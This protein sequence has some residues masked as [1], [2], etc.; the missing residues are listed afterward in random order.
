MTNQSD[1]LS[2]SLALLER[3]VGFD[4]VSTKTN[5]PLIEAVESYLG[6][7]GIAFTRVPNAAG[8][9][10]ALFAT[11]GPAGDGGVRALGPHGR[12][13]G[14]GPGLG[15]RSR[16]ACGARAAGCTGAAPAT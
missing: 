6:D 9:K 10:A 3:L 16:S 1:D 14:G 15:G 2:A 4:T 7:Y 5:L 8:D 13:A 12:G 11:V